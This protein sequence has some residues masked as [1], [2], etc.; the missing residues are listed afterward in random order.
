MNF[1]GGFIINYYSCGIVILKSK[2]CKKKF[3]SLMYVTFQRRFCR[4]FGHYR[5]I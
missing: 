3:E 1:A 2:R 5:D 4:K